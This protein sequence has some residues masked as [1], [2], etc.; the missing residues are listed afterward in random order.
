MCDPFGSKKA[1]K[2]ARRDSERAARETK[3]QEEKRQADILQGNQN[4]DTAFGQYDDG[5]FG[6]YKDAYTGNYN[7]QIDDQFGGALD[8]LKAILAGRGQLG[9]TVGINKIGDLVEKRDE[10][11]AQVGNDAETAAGDLRS[12]IEKS[13]T[14]LYSLNQASADPQGI[15][16]RA[17]GE[18]TSL[19]APPSYSPL[20]ELFSSTLA[21]YLAYQQSARYAAPAGTYG[22]RYA[23]G[24]G[25]SGRVVS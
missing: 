5:F 2:R 11:R 25:S 12:R 3:A 7:P 6:G 21:P 4:I 14:N 22:S 1:A 18:A 10:A 24:G 16:A 8:K 20:G 23:S 15:M 17:T 13:K 19:A 9:G